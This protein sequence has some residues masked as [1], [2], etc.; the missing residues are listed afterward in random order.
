VLDVSP[1]FEK[2]TITVTFDKA[3]TNTDVMKKALHDAG[4]PVDGEAVAAP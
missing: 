2:H 4:F 3:K 1:D